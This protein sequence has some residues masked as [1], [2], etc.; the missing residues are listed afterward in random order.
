MQQGLELVGQETA[1]RIEWELVPQG[2]DKV[3]LDVGV[4]EEA[5]AEVVVGSLDVQHVDRMDD[6]VDIVLVVDQKIMSMLTAL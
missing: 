5:E 6:F 4:I 3:V 1:N 2:V